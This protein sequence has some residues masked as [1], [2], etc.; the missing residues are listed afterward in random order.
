M[1]GTPIDSLELQIQS[2]AKGAAAG[3]DN[4]VSKLQNLAS[5]VAS[6]DTHRMSGI[7]TAERNIADASVG[8]KGGR[9]NE[10][11]SLASALNSFD[12]VNTGAVYSSANAIE[13]LAGSMAQI[14]SVN[15][16]AQGIINAAMA[17]NK[18]GGVKAISGTSNLQSV[19]NDLISF[20]QGLNSVGTVNFDVTNLVSVISSVSKLGGKSAISATENLP[21]ISK[22]LLTFIVSLNQL[23]SLKFDTTGMTS[24]VASISKLGGKSS[25]TA[26]T[27]IPLLTKSLM[28]MMNTLSKAPTVSNNLIQMTN[29]LA[30]LASQGNKVGIASNK[31]SSGFNLMNRSVKSS[32]GHWRGLA[33]AI[34]KFYA[35]YF[36]VIRAIRIL[37]KAVNYSSELTEVQNVVDVTFGKMSGKVEEF[38]KNSIKQL[39]MSELSVK[40]YASRFQAMGSA[41]GIGSNQVGNAN[42]F[43][44][45][46]TNGYV[47]LSDSM[48]DVSLNLTKL[49]ADM[50]SFYD[51]SQKDVAEDLQAIFT[52]QTRPL[53]EYGIDLTQATL[54]EWALKNGLDAD[55]SS[56]SQAEKT[57]LRYQY[58]LAN[59]TA[60]QGD[61]ARTSDTWANQIRI[62]KQ[63]FQQLGL[64]IGKG[65]IAAFKPFIRGLNSV[66][67]KVISFSETVLN[68]LGQIFGWKF[69]IS[70][71]GITDDIDDVSSGM[72]D[73]SDGAGNTASGIKDATDAAKKFKS[74]VLGI[75]EL[76]L[77]EPDNDTGSG[78]GGSGGSG[79]GGSS[80]GSS[81]GGLTTKME[82]SDGILKAYESNIKTLYQL[83]SYI[84]G[85]IADSLNAIDWNSVYEKARN[86]G[87]GLADF[88]NGL[89]TPDLF[90]AVGKT[91]ANSLNT[92]IY[93]ALSLGEGIN[94]Y[95]YGESV[96]EGINQF[97]KNFDF[98]SLAETLNVWVD[99]LELFIK[100]FADKIEWKYIFSG[101]RDFFSNLEID[102]VVVAIGAIAWKF[103]AFSAIKTALLTPITTAVSQMS[104]QSVAILIR[105]GIKNGLSKL[106]GSV[107]P[108]LAE[109]LGISAGAATVVVAVVA[110]IGIAIKDLWDTSESFR[111]SV[112]DMWDNI[113]ETISNAWTII[114]DNT[115]KPGFEDVQNLFDSLG[116]LWS[117]IYEAYESS[118]AKALFEKIVVFLGNTLVMV[119]KT[120]ITMAATF[121]QV[122]GNA[123]GTVIKVITAVI[124]F[125]TGVF[126]GD[127][128]TAWQDL[129]T[130]IITIFSPITDWFSEKFNAAYNA[131]KSAWAF[132][133]T[134]A[135]EKWNQIKAP[136]KSVK[137]W[138]SD[139]FQTAYDSVKKIWK[140][141]G[142]FFSG[143]AN[144]IISPIGNAVNGIISGVNWV[145]SKVGSKTRL[146]KWS[147][148][149]FA[150]GADGLPQDTVG[151]VNDQPGNTYKE[152]IVPKNG[153]P[154]IPKGR[155]VVLPME[156]GTKIMPADQTKALMQSVGVPRFAGGIGQFFNN[157]WESAKDIAG[158]IAD[159]IS[160]PDKL[161]QIAL[162][163]FVDISNFVH[164]ISDIAG[165]VVKTTFNS[166]KDYIKGKL[167]AFVPKVTYSPSGGVE[168]WRAVA[169]QALRI[170][171]QLSDANINAL[172][173]QMK[174][175]SG[176]NPNAINNWDINAK[177]GTPSKGLMQV[178]DPTFRAYALAPY[179][180]NIYDPLS[181]M[182]AAIRYT[183]SR[184]GSLYNGWTKRGYIGYKTGIGAI[185]LSD[186][187]KYSVGG[188]P[189]DGLFMANRKEL[190][191]QFNGRNA[192]VN[193]YQIESGI[194][195]AVYNGYM[196]AHAQ[197]TREVSVLEE[198]LTAVREGKTI[199]ID[200]REIVRVYDSRK[201]RNGYAFT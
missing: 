35:T 26:I 80:A 116:K 90:G 187:P 109:F 130:S 166:I 42:A 176:G 127:W 145:L 104:F 45:N 36:L 57:M 93:V 95:G 150:S 65:V 189:E 72:D 167:D 134:W 136:F 193:N 41:M 40:Q 1:A 61:F 121:I 122:I 37:G 197:D 10:I 120:N 125:I 124:D 165:G 100:G 7:A 28:T 157:A 128:Q 19:K 25:T 154:F 92:A 151:M 83:G 137:K 101:I 16:N 188:F 55:I 201:A 103:G 64:V 68:A 180:T 75:D 54:K 5:A 53:R 39:G 21:K 52:G 71:G 69:E 2:N 126:S 102:T 196:R 74:V 113:K 170:T 144:D 111:N 173:N 97:F 184:Y 18:L 139:A 99:N 3:L 158:G 12:K 63:Q 79:G 192:V 175:E 142:K 147:V 156:K 112:S 194:E 8:F 105:D 56:M 164:P 87:S 73:L 182:I 77:N 174:H 108:N 70:A 20:A 49:T 181:N 46:K 85:T 15:F 43:L 169:T 143:I 186:L 162:N 89:I 159:Y 96:A 62:L 138:F 161:L 60:A 195:K 76:N 110:A 133:G 177:N 22:N 66:L 115:L 86:F 14:S 172:L 183:V 118:G 33:S 78:S 178:I 94:A 146:D 190:V 149:R 17:L 31:I 9:S 91:I 67:G 114:W 50:A 141:I 59:T 131:I 47:G 148:P 152:M 155:N 129:K 81:S 168:Q 84:S 82:A 179:N 11:R 199:S 29:A 200:G 23:Q 4:M 13:K 163:K 153:E 185:S 51:V 123:V 48:A 32:T 135:S 24:L 27:T 34:G 140:G 171:N 30:N 88:L 44:N 58:V 160:H 119:F 6:V 98:S 117:A 198:I 38:S 191:G 107:I 106:S 132:V